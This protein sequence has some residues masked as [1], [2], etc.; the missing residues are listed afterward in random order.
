MNTHKILT[1]LTLLISMTFACTLSNIS[2]EPGVSQFYT[3]GF[4][5]Q[6]SN[7]TSADWQKDI[8]I[9][10]LRTEDNIPIGDI[11]Q[12]PDQKVKYSI[13][14][15]GEIVNGFFYVSSNLQLDKTYIFWVQAC[16]SQLQQNF[17]V[18]NQMGIGDQVGNSIIWFKNNIFVIFIAIIIIVLLILVFRPLIPGR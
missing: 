18:V 17:T 7:V 3:A 15:N 16:N 11:Y 8:D 13:P 9:Y 10:V 5:I 14:D 2:V 4:T 1:I 12:Y 6:L